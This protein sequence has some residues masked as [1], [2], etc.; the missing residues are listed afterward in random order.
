MGNGTAGGTP[1]YLLDLIR[2]RSPITRAELSS[3]TGLARSTIAQRVDQLISEGLVGEVGEALSTGG[4]PATILGFNADSGVVL[5]ADLG[6]THSRLAV[7]DLAANPLAEARRDIDIADGPEAV[8]TWVL[9]T[10][11]TLTA[12]AGRRAADVRGIGIGVPGPVDF[13]AGRAVHPPIMP[14]WDDFPIRDRF[15]ERYEVP[16]LVDNDVNIMALGEYWAMHP[17]VA[18][19]IFVKVGTGIGSGLIIGGRLHRGARGAAGDIGHVQ[20]GSA[21][22]MCRCGNPGCLEASAGGAAIA[23][24]L[25]EK[26]HDAVGSRDVAGL[27]QVGNHDAIQAVRESG[28]LIGSVLAATVNLLNPAVISI[29]GDLVEAGQQLL[30]GIRETVYQRS[31][32]LSTSELRITTGTLG[33]RAGI[34]G[35]AALVIEHVFDP[36]RVDAALVVSMG[37][38]DS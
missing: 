18:D 33:D 15:V 38:Q 12:D 22:I 30:A 29:G 20:A 37:A 3:I 24:D 16:V 25:R 36:K 19:L 23:R 35:A 5:V 28:R 34:I 31:T 9:E 7:C 17:K 8:L 13:A 21:E 27:V 1:G 14:G 2:R 4:R 11:E 6:A 32:A 10:F 26:G